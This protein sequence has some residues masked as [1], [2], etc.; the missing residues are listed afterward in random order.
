MLFL[1]N[2]LIP[3]CNFARLDKRI[4]MSEKISLFQ[5]SIN[6]INIDNLAKLQIGIRKFANKSR[7][8]RDVGPARISD[9]SYI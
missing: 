9:S 1:A 7:I 8:M 6:K 3:I 5:P 2:F 4:F